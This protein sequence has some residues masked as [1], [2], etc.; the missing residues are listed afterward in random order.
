VKSAEPTTE[1][2]FDIDHMCRF[3]GVRSRLVA[4]DQRECRWMSA[5][6]FM[7]WGPDVLEIPIYLNIL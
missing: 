6:K 5:R 2:P 7:R 4:R 1:I 3:S